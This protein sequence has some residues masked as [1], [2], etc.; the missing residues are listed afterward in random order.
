[1]LLWSRALLGAT[2]EPLLRALS[3]LD[4]LPEP[5]RRLR[6]LVRGA[7]RAVRARIRSDRACP[8]P[9]IRSRHAIVLHALRELALLRVDPPPGPG[10]HGPGK[11]ARSDRP[12]APVSHLLRRSGRLGRRQ[13]RPAAAR[14]SDGPGADQ[15]RTRCLTGTWPRIG[16]DSPLKGLP[17]QQPPELPHLLLQLAAPP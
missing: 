14:G 11:H 1:M 17:L 15:G 13:R 2:T 3:L 16:P 10:R 8:L 7:T 6:Y 9:L 4:V 5:R 12:A